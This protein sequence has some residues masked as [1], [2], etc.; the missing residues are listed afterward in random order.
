MG[1]GGQ[2]HAPD[3]LPS[4]KTRHPLY[5]RLGGPQGRSERVRKI[6]PPPSFDPRTVQPLARHYIDLAIPAPDFPNYLRVNS[7][8]IFNLSKEHFLK[9]TLKLQFTYSLSCNAV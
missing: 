7:E 3:A 6:T 9:Y 8:I 4:G 2:H 1:M 5:S